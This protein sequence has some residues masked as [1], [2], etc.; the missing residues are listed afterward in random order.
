MPKINRLEKG[1]CDVDN[2]I[3]FQEIDK[4]F[5]QNNI[6]IFR[7]KHVIF[8][9]GAG[10]SVNSGIPDFRS[11]NGIFAEIRKNLNVKGQ[12]LFSFHFSRDQKHDL[13]ISNLFPN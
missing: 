1:K 2:K 3:T 5:I 12:D 11:K 6:T 9:V 13:C 10:I 4:D 7:R 8:V